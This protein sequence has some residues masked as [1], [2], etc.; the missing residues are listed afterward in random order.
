MKINGKHHHLVSQVDIFRLKEG[1]RPI[2][3]AIHASGGILTFAR[4]ARHLDPDQPMYVV[5]GKGLDAPHHPFK[6]IYELAEHYVAEMLKISPDGPF[7]ICGRQTAILIEVGQQLLLRQKLVISTLVFDTR[8]QQPKN[9]PLK[10]RARNQYRELKGRLSKLPS[11]F[12][13]IRVKSS[14]HS[15]VGRVVS[16]VHSS[17][18]DLSMV[19][20]VR[21]RRFIDG[22]SSVRP[23]SINRSLMSNYVM[24]P[25]HARIV[26]IQ[27]AEYRHLRGKADYPEKW[28]AL[29]DEVV[30]HTVP[31]SH[32][33]VFESPNVEILAHVVQSECDSVTRQDEHCN[34]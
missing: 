12:S 16:S 27:S 29:S 3:F 31:G 26:Y 7:I 6:D 15:L 28:R 9:L 23:R 18:P 17:T 4:M 34:D 21:V 14:L 19:D 20:K 22:S 30:V 5:K 8:P 2:L 24:K 25:Y 1:Q 32:A 33:G 11:L 13:P 10:R